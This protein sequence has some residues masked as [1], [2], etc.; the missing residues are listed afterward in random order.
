MV[1]TGNMFKTYCF[2]CKLQKNYHSI[3]THSHTAPFHSPRSP[4]QGRGKARPPFDFHQ[5][6]IMTSKGKRNEDWGEAEA[7]TYEDFVEFFTG[8]NCGSHRRFL[9]ALVIEPVLHCKS[10][11]QLRFK[12]PGSRFQ[13]TRITHSGSKPWFTPMTLWSMTYS[14]DCPWKLRRTSGN[15]SWTVHMFAKTKW[16]QTIKKDVTSDWWLD[17]RSKFTGMVWRGLV[18]TECQTEREHR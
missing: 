13:L 14:Q 10:S 5:V 11:W 12:V 9:F 1:Y 3:R 17:L 7:M 18:H 16:E 8:S 6:I 15:W 2:I 4:P